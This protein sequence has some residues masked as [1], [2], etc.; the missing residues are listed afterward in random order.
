MSQCL[1]F[2]EHMALDSNNLLGSFLT[3]I[4]KFYIRQWPPTSV[5]GSARKC[6][7]WEIVLL[8]GIDFVLQI[9]LNFQLPG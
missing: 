8:I 9:S 5:P 3:P 1:A 2:F 6:L 4:I 7:A